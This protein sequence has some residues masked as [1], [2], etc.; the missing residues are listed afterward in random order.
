LPVYL[1]S[2][3]TEKR[4]WKSG[5]GK[6]KNE[7]FFK[8]FYSLFKGFKILALSLIVY[9]FQVVLIADKGLYQ[10]NKKAFDIYKGHQVVLFSFQGV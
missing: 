4:K 9:S 7:N 8:G 5:K 2:G 3:K 1:E 6:R 10:A